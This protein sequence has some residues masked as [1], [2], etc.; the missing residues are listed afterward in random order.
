MMDVTA[1]PSAEGHDE[2]PEKLSLKARLK[3]FEK[4]IEQQGSA[5]PA[6]KPEKKF[7]FLN[8]DEI[9]KMKEEEEKRI[10]QMTTFEFSKT[11]ETA[12][13][14]ADSWTESA[15]ED[16]AQMDMMARGEPVPKKSL[17]SGPHSIPYTA[18]GE[19]LLRERLERENA[20]LP[21]ES[22]N[23]DNMSPEEKKEVEAE[24]RAAWRKARLKSLENDAIQAQLVIQKMSELSTQESSD[25]L[26]P[27]SEGSPSKTLDEDKH[28]S[29]SENDETLDDDED[30]NETTQDVQ[31]ETN[32]QNNDNTLDT[33]NANLQITDN[34]NNIPR[35]RRYK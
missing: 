7:S 14:E 17:E 13:H 15:L 1:S 9:A 24:R 4:E 16:V 6:P 32:F 3:L 18:K 28:E 10:A 34:Q 25:D 26:D 2:S 30:D 33:A 11:N 27:I 29:S 5:A 21:E 19:R 23:F 31:A 35:Y 12:H 8:P 22:E 20:E